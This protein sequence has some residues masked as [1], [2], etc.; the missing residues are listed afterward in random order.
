MIKRCFFKAQIVFWL[1][2]ATDGHAKNFSLFRTYNNGYKLTPLY[3]VLSAFPVIGDNQNQVSFH[4]AKLAMSID[5]KN[6]HYA[7]KD[8][9]KRHFIG[10][11]TKVCFSEI[12]AKTMI[13]EVAENTVDVV[14]S[15]KTLLPKNFPNSISD[16]IFT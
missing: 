9:Q 3:D 7:V 10:H 4:K 13:I 16:K 12:E 11:A 1:L 5:S 15:V 8:I 14:N 2:R 6:R